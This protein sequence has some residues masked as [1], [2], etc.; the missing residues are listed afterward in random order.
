MYK[1]CSPAGHFHLTKTSLV[2]TRPKYFV[3]SY[4][5]QCLTNLFNFLSPTVCKSVTIQCF[6][7]VFQNKI[8]NRTGCCPV[9][10]D[11]KLTSSHDVPAVN[12]NRIKL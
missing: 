10:T 3:S 4:T 9:C 11:S 12:F 1:D 8:L 2:D 5:Q 7:F 6:S